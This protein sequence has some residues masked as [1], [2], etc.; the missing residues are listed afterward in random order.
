M[1]HRG[2]AQWTELARKRAGLPVLQ[3]HGT[4]DPILPYPAALELKRVLDD[5]GV[6]VRFHSF[7]GGH[8]IDGAA[9]ELFGEMLLEVCA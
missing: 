4:H 6:R 5:A 7:P 1:Q 8:G 2:R 9:L 3:A